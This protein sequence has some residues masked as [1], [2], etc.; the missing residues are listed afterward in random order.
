M[1]WK[2]AIRWAAVT[3]PVTVALGLFGVYT[4]LRS[5]SFDALVL[6]TLEQH[7]NQSLGG[8]THI[9]HLDLD[10]GTLTVRL[11]DVTIH[12][13]ERQATAPLLH[14]DQLTVGLTISSVIHGKV[15]LRLLEVTHPVAHIKVNGTGA[16]NLPSAPSS[17]SHST[18]DIFDLAV[19][20]FAITNGEIYFND[21][22]VP[23]EADL[24]DLNSAVVFDPATTRYTGTVS[25]HDG[26][27]QY[28]GYPSMPHSLATTFHA[29]RS[30]LSIDSISLRVG[31]STLSANGTV[32]DYAEP[33]AIGAYRISVYSQ[34][35]NSMS[36]GAQFDGDLAFNGDFQYHCPRNRTA[37]RCLMVSGRA[38]SGE[39]A[40]ATSEVSAA[41]SDLKASYLLSDGRL[42]V[43]VA[44]ARSLGGLIRAHLEVSG[45]DSH[46]D[47]RLHASFQQV[48]LHS[49]QDAA[50][51]AHKGDLA[52]SGSLSGKVEAQWTESLASLRGSSDVVIHGSA[53]SNRNDSSAAVPV[54]GSIHVAY[55]G[56]ES[57]LSLRQSTIAIPSA[58]VTADGHI[59]RHSRLHLTAHAD[60]L[61]QLIRL[62]ES[63]SPSHKSLPSIYGTADLNA[64]LEGSL[65]QPLI[66]A[67]FGLNNLTVR[68]TTLRSIS[69]TL[70]ANPSRI[71]ISNGKVVGA[72]HGDGSFSGSAALR[73]WRYQP[74]DLIRFKASIRKVP[75]KDIETLAN[76]TYPV[77]GDLSADVSLNGSQLSPSGFGS[78][79]LTKGSA[80]GEQIESLA[81]T[82]VAANGTI[83]TA[84]HCAIA[85]GHADA[86][87]SY[88]TSTK[89]YMFQLAAPTV[90]LQKLRI[91]QAKNIALNGTL[92]A[93]A[94]GQGTL[95]HPQVNAVL[96]SS[97]ISLEGQTISGLTA[98]TD[99]RNER[100]SFAMAAQVNGAPLQARASV[101]LMGDYEA[102]A[103]IDTGAIP[104]Q[105]LLT[106]FAKG[107]PAGFQGDTELHATLKGPLNN[108][109]SL[110][111]HI[112][113]PTLW[114]S[115]QQLQVRAMAPIRAHYV[116]S[117]VTL[118]PVEISGTDTSLRLQGALPL[119]GSSRPTLAA[120]GWVDVRVLRILDPDLQGSGAV[121]FDVHA[122]GTSAS[123]SVEGQVILQDVGLSTPE[124]PI[125]IY[126]LNGT[127]NLTNDRLQIANAS[128]EIGGGE[129]SIGGSIIYRPSLQFDVAL[130]GKS[131][132]LRY[133]AG[134]RTIL[135]TNLTL[136]GN[137]QASTL[138]GRVLIDSLSFT[139]DFDLA[140][141]GDQLNGNGV[142][143]TQPGFG[144]TVSL[145]VTVQSTNNLSA[146][147]SQL[148]IEGSANLRVGGTAADPVVFGRLDLTSGELF[149]RNNRYQLQRGII[150][151]DNPTMTSPTLD[152]SVTSTV[153]QYN[154]TIGLRGPLGRLSTSYTSDPPLAA[155]DIINLIAFGKTSSESA[156]ANSS[157]TTDSIIASG[158][159]SAI[160]SEFSGGIQKLAGL[161]S[162]QIDPLLGGNSQNPSAQI[163]LQ[164]RVT[165]NFLFTF[166]TDVSQPGEELVQGEY[167]INK[168]WSV[169]VTRNQVGGVS[170]DG[171]LH[172]R[173]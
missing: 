68:N 37:L 6:R 62:V 136:S 101:A 172:T 29:T 32:T 117:V 53:A 121:R 15:D 106:S 9:G 96:R 146:Q 143:P 13:E 76:A 58:K 173:F 100:G 114:A 55:D 79:T 8:S 23:L 52:L 160:G 107:V 92:S 57:R 1:Q 49:L 94:T 127:L 157:Q 20:H 167:Q 66:A 110:E 120:K 137:T 119:M 40:A 89:A 39:F 111:A 104:L 46:P 24:H 128:A 85:A 132:R 154:L 152:V 83:R 149:Y 103:S 142:T 164:Q 93:S 3:L 82:F 74:A 168:R 165:K 33:T 10:L 129:V 88:A 147:S 125:G 78:L 14:I 124:A 73:N 16:T 2:R 42:R 138:N 123:S 90:T 43:E 140:T 28:A 35:F 81:T 54:D 45:L 134:L 67:Q 22:T 159:Q 17:E 141:F 108:R 116:H 122:S 163:A 34:D 150:T 135:D 171:R 71:T 145:A 169:I 4:Y 30:A 170:V 70:F 80:Y 102:E 26:R 95:D 151:F 144:N 31:S 148:N 87:M 161:S 47:S 50:H 48:S 27:V 153:E 98:E 25:Y 36:R 130:R 139:P 65:T 38:A 97:R 59:S 19:R 131:V 63:V 166:S 60:D 51:R 84:F 12:G 99:V 77:S 75:L 105:I 7:A 41:L 86:T 118:Q 61:H 133:P 56:A 11:Y 69:L 162:L 112:T 64:T 156:A 126:K 44:E 155:A 91:M 21:A 109:T 113:I 18:I 115:Y 72:I 5:A 158:A